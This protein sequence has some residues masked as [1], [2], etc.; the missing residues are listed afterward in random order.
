[1]KKHKFSKIVLLFFTLL[2]LTNCEKTADC[3]L[4]R[5]PN[6]IAKELRNGAVSTDYNENIAFEIKNENVSNYMISSLSIDGLPKGIN[7]GVIDN[8]II[9]LKGVPV[10]SGT[11]EFKVT[12]TVEP[13]DYDEEIGDN[14][15][16]DTTTR[17]YK[18]KI[19]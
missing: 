15:C 9:N 18:I 3:I 16:G 7:Y 8:R 13:I 11:Y 1:M 14:L 6:L 19:N 10:A 5:S 17:S 12:I 2:L 4:G